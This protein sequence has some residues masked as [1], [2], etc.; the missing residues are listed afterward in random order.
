MGEAHPAEALLTA[1]LLQEPERGFQ[2]ADWMHERLIKIIVDFE[3]NL[4][5]HMQAGGRLV[6]FQDTTFGIENIRHLNPDIIIF[7]GTLPDQTRVELIQH[8]SQLNLLLVAVPL[9]DSSAP[10]RKIGFAPR[11]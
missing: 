7:E 9:S 2:N 10:R 6:S 3:L 5:D 11:D 8:T 4:P 1:N